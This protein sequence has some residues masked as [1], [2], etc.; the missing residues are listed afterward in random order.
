MGEPSLLTLPSAKPCLSLMADI[1]RHYAV[2]TASTAIEAL[3]LLTESQQVPG[4]PNFD[5]VLTDLKLP[6]VS[7]F[8]LIQQVVAGRNGIHNIPVV[9]MSSEDSRDSVMQVRRSGLCLC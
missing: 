7:G 4:S 2:T 6:E 9:V 3:K 1:L 5:L 8:D